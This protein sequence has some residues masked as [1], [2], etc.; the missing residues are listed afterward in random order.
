MNCREL[1]KKKSEIPLWQ[2]R[3]IDLLWETLKTPRASSAHFIL[4]PEK[5]RYKRGWE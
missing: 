1:A 4:P 3:L 5:K 2:E